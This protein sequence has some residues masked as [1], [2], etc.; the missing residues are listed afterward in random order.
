[1]MLFHSS[2]PQWDKKTGPV[3]RFILTDQGV[4]STRTYR[5]DRCGDVV[6]VD[7]D[8]AEGATPEAN[9]TFK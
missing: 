7:V 6:H 4:A 1:M 3:P 8:W 9:A 5:C 2:C